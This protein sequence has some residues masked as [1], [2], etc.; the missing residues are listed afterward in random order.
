M[1]DRMILIYLFH[2]LF[3]LAPSFAKTVEFQFTSPNF[4]QR[5]TANR[6]AFVRRL[7]ND[8]IVRIFATECEVIQKPGPRHYTLHGIEVEPGRARVQYLLYL[9]DQL[10]SSA[11]REQ[12]CES[13]PLAERRYIGPISNVPVTNFDGPNGIWHAPESLFGIFTAVRD[14]DRSFGIVFGM[15]TYYFNACYFEDIAGLDSVPHP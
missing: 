11:D 10:L 8:R 4:C 14:R 3:S 13:Q 7:P 9:D 12:T 5:I 15:A 6:V 2:S 1:E